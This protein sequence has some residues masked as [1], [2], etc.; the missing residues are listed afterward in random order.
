MNTQDNNSSRQ[1]RIPA[2]LQAVFLASNRGK[3][4]NNPPPAKVA[5]K[6]YHRNWLFQR[7]NGSKARTGGV[8]GGTLRL[9]TKRDKK[10]KQ[11]Q[12]RKDA[13][14]VQAVQ[15]LKAKVRKS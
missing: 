9:L 13:P 15:V 14:Q 3:E 1:G 2:T 7:Q 11:T 6:V 10:T 4:V 12:P 5:S 8:F